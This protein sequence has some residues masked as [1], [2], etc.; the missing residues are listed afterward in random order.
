MDT[1]HTDEVLAGVRQAL[2]ASE[3]S[4]RTSPDTEGT[5]SII[6]QMC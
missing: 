5:V 6:L 3:R 2:D 1:H 4:W